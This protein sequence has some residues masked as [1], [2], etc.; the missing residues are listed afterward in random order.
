[1]VIAV[2]RPMPPGHCGRFCGNLA[3]SVAARALEVRQVVEIV[4]QHVALVDFARCRRRDDDG[5]GVEVA[6]VG[7][8]RGQRRVMAQALE[9]AV[10]A[11]RSRAEQQSRGQTAKGDPS[12]ETSIQ[13]ID[14]LVLMRLPGRVR[15]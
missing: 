3:N 9:N 6:V 13:H 4:D 7:D 1:M 10:R 8:R 2:L 14:F 12:D 11:R 5:V 15:T